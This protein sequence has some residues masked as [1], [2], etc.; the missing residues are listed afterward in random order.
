ML[1]KFVRDISFKII[2]FLNGYCNLLIIFSFSFLCDVDISVCY[3]QG[4]D[5]L[6][7][8]SCFELE[9]HR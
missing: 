1:V 9:N 4:N 5:I 2:F 6:F 3:I 7:N 8:Y